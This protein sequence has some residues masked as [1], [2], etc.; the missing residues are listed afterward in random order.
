MDEASREEETRQVTI[1]KCNYWLKMFMLYVIRKWS[2]LKLKR[3]MTYWLSVMNRLVR[4][5]VDVRKI[6]K[7]K[8]NMYLARCLMERDF[9]VVYNVSLSESLGN[10]GCCLNQS[11]NNSMCFANACFETNLRSLCCS[12]EL[13]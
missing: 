12:L 7:L 9:P 6:P 2:N 4:Y 5:K 1:Y 8:N 13:E 11:T 3:S 10:G